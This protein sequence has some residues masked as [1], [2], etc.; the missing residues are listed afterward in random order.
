MP[1]QMKQLLN[2]Q[3]LLQGELLHL[4]HFLPSKKKMPFSIWKMGMDRSRNHS[5]HMSHPKGEERREAEVEV[6][7][8]REEDS[9]E[10]TLRSRITSIE[11][12]QIEVDGSPEAEMEEVVMTEA[13][14]KGNP[15]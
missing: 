13:Q 10:V 1:E 12:N 3:L 8:A 6:E 5:N 11:D 14:I 15:G 4:P 7:M 9:R 2:L